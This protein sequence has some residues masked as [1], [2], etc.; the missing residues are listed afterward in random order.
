LETNNINELEA[1]IPSETVRKYILETGWTFTDF[2]KAALI[3]HNVP[4]LE[5]QCSLL[6]DLRGKTE[7]TVL[8]DQITEYF[9][10]EERAFEAFK[11]NDGK[12]SVYVL[13]VREIGGYWDGNDFPRGYFFDWKTAVGY[14]KKE[15]APFQVEKYSVGVVE[16]SDDGT[17]D[18]HSTGAVRFDGNGELIDISSETPHIWNTVSEM[19]EHFTEMY[20]EVPNPF[21]KGDVVKSLYGYYGIVDDSQKE[22]KENVEKSKRWQSEN[23][24]MS[25]YDIILWVSVLEED[26]TFGIG[27][28]TPLELERYQPQNLRDPL[29]MLLD[30]ASRVTR[31]ECG[32]GE[33]FRH[34]EEYQ[35]SIG[36]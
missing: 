32:L 22:W 2:Q 29:D 12:T 15:N 27:E 9:D 14:G 1:M 25:F 26:G 11:K 6:R 34:M 28:A 4:P 33:L 17:C 35:D 23:H 7:D 8:R 5:K 30:T 21:E 19:S 31:G 36:D 24:N 3:F 20:F 10:V 13:K 16:K 18:H